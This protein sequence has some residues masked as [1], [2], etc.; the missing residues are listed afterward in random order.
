VDLASHDHESTKE[1]WQLPFSFLCGEQ[2]EILLLLP[3][4]RMRVMSQ[5]LELQPSVSLSFH[6]ISE[7]YMLEIRIEL[8][9]G[10]KK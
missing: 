3:L 9:S 1:P 6:E 8:K 10:I 2:W 7:E 5:S 4:N